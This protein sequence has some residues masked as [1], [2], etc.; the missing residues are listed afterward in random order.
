MII[1]A[2]GSGMPAGTDFEFDGNY[3]LEFGD[4]GD[5][6]QQRNALQIIAGSG[7]FDVTFTINSFGTGQYT[8]DG[9]R[10]WVIS[11]VDEFVNVDSS[12]AIGGG[13]AFSDS[14]V[15]DAGGGGTYTCD[16]KVLSVT[17]TGFPEI[18]FDRVEK[19]LA[20]DN[21]IPA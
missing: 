18:T 9:E 5:F 20:P 10:I 4:Q 15:F 2:A 8:A 11:V 16:E 19:S 13:A 12:I 1:A 21:T 7:G 3:Y 6:K 17:T 14:N